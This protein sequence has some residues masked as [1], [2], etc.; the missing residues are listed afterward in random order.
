[1]KIDNVDY[2]I[3][4]HRHL[5]MTFNNGSNGRIIF[6]GDWFSDGSYAEWDG[7]ELYLKSFR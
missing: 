1:M 5:P 4:G 2:F 7:S 3:F 6:L